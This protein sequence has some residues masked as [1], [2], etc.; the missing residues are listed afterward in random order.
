METHWD[1]HWI[2]I[3]EPSYGNAAGNVLEYYMETWWES[4]GVSLET[5]RNRSSWNPI[6]AIFANTTGIGLEPNRN[7]GFLPFRFI[8]TDYWDPMRIQL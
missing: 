3:E 7:P 5:S 1:L 8:W 4:F 2:T 6:G